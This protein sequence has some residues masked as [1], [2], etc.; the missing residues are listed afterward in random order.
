[1]KKT[2][3]IISCLFVIS[4][5]LP[6]CS[7]LDTEAPLPEQKP[8]TSKVCLVTDTQG[9]N[10]RSFNATAWKGVTD[11]EAQ[12]GIIGS[13]LE[14]ED[15]TYYD[16]NISAFIQGGCDLIVTVGYMIGDATATAAEAHPEQK[17]AIVDVDFLDFSVDPPSDVVFDNV[18]ELTFRTDEAAFLAGYLAAGVTRTGIVGTFGGLDIPTVT[19]F[20][21]G[22]Y[23]GVTHYNEKHGTDVQLLGWDPFLRVGL[24]TKTFDDVHKGVSMGASLIDEGADIIMPVAGGV[25]LGT[26][27]IAKE[28]GNVYIIGVDTDWTVSA[29][30]YSDIILTSVLKNMDVAVFNASR[31]VVDGIFSGGL[32]IGTL[33]NDGVGMASYHE[34]DPLVSDELKLELE[35][36]KADIIAGDIPTLP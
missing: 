35:Q 26:A 23:L 3:R 13:Y 5:M 28:R 17:Y 32:Y 4:L 19:S 30:E 2:S 33:A 7:L 6:A 22:F 11:A 16:V 29:P 31:E 34:L 25:G 9:I 12:Q 14:S 10:D 8:V 18:K 1:M 20:M 15:D 24:F 27:A 36:V 21:D